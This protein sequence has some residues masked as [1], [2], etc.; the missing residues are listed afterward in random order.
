MPLAFTYNQLELPK[1]Y[2]KQNVTNITEALACERANFLRKIPDSPCPTE[3]NLSI[4]HSL[5]YPPNAD[6]DAAAPPVPVGNIFKFHQMGVQP[7]TVLLV[8]DSSLRVTAVSSNCTDW[9]GCGPQQLLGRAAADLFDEGQSKML[10]V[11]HALRTSEDSAKEHRL[12][13]TLVTP[14]ML[15]STAGVQL[16]GL[17]NKSGKHFTLELER[18]TDKQEE[19]EVYNTLKDLAAQL[20]AQAKGDVKAICN[21]VVGV[22]R[23]VLQYDR[24]I[25]YKF[26]ED[27]HGE[28]LA[29]SLSNPDFMSL[30]GLHFPG[31]DVPWMVRELL[32]ARR[33][34]W[35]YDVDSK[36]VHIVHNGSFDGSPIKHAHFV[37]VHP[38]HL[39]YLKNMGL[40]SSGTL[41]IV[42]PHAPRK[43]WG[44]IA[45]HG[46]LTAKP[47]SFAKLVTASLI[48]ELFCSYLA[49]ALHTEAHLRDLRV[50]RI[51]AMLLEQLQLTTGRE[52]SHWGIDM[53][54]M[55]GADG[56]ALMLSGNLL[57]M[58]VHPSHEQI[59]DMVKWLTE[60]RVPRG[61]NYDKYEA[62]P[63]VE[64]SLRKVGFTDL[65]KVDVCGVLL[66]LLDDGDFVVWF[67][68]ESACIVQWPA[69]A[70]QAAREEF[71]KILNPHH[72]F[73]LLS[74][75]Q[76]HCSKPW[77]ASDVLIAQN[78]REV[79]QDSVTNRKA[80]S[81]L[82]WEAKVKHNLGR[83]KMINQLEKMVVNLRKVVTS[84]H[85]SIVC[86]NTS[87]I[88]TEWNENMEAATGYTQD[89]ALGSNLVTTFVAPA[90]QQIVT[91]SIL[92]A[93]CGQFCENGIE[94][95]LKGKNSMSI[96][97]VA[98]FS[99]RIS[100]DGMASAIYV[101]CNNITARKEVE[102]EM[103]LTRAQLQDSINLL[104]AG[105]AIFDENMVLVICNPKFRQLFHVPQSSHALANYR[106]ILDNA[107]NEGAHESSGLPRDQ[108]IERVMEAGKDP[109]ASQKI[110][111]NNQWIAVSY[112]QANNGGAVCMYSDLTRAM[113]EERLRLAKEAAEASSNAKSDFLA[114]MSHEI[115]TP[116]NS[117]LG[118]GVLLQ[119]TSLTTEQEEYVDCILS[120]GKLLL[121]LISDILDLSKI[122][123]GM[124]RVEQTEFNLGTELENMVELLIPKAKEKS[125]Y[126]H[127]NIHPDVP[128]LLCGD[129]VKLRQVLLNLMGNAVK[130]TSS[131]SVS[132]SVSLVNHPS[133]P[134]PRAEDPKSG[135]A[136]KGGQTAQRQGALPT[137]PRKG[138]PQP[139]QGAKHGER[140][141]PNPPPPAPQGQDLSSP[142]SPVAG[143]GPQ[144]NST[145]GN[146]AKG[147]SIQ[148]N[149]AQGNSMQ[150]GEGSGSVSCANAA[151]SVTLH[152]EVQDTGIG[153]SEEDASKLFQRFT[154]A[155][156]STTRKYGGTGL[157]LVICRK[158][159]ELMSPNN[160]VDVRSK[161]GEGSCFWF[162]IYIQTQNV[163]YPPRDL[164]PPMPR[165][166]IL[167]HASGQLTGLAYNLERLGFA[168]E[169]IDEL[170]WDTFDKTPGVNLVVV[171][172][173]VY[174]SMD[175]AARIKKRKVPESRLNPATSRFKRPS[176]AG[177]SGS[178]GDPGT[179]LPITVTGSR[180]P[181]ESLDNSM[182]LRM[183]DPVDGEDPSCILTDDIPPSTMTL[184]VVRNV[185]DHG[186]RPLMQSP[187]L[188]LLRRNSAM[189]VIEPAE[190]PGLRLPVFFVMLPARLSALWALIKDNLTTEVIG[191][192]INPGLI[193][194]VISPAASIQA[195]PASSSEAE[196]NAR[197]SRR[198]SAEYDSQQ[199]QGAKRRRVL[200]AEDNPVNQRLFVKFLSTMGCDVEVVENGQQA[201]EKVRN[202]HTQFDICFM[203]CQMPTLDGLEATK[204]IR[205]EEAEAE[206]AGR[207]PR[208]LPIVAV[209]AN[210]F[211]ED[212]E[213]C[214]ACGMDDYI[215]KPVMKASILETLNR[216]T[217]LTRPE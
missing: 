61:E 202:F 162:D 186:A 69:A 32:L 47:V 21:V 213:R 150:G 27:E 198:S 116:M 53:M 108:W 153:I 168:T 194:R 35:I 165:A 142:M 29:E 124:M 60:R 206:R 113:E 64:V 148:G 143:D 173:E 137:S 92:Q 6:G 80:R 140:A 103:Q 192:L 207:K 37:E 215:T 14:L 149:G 93:A 200:L 83:V 33:M 88:I 210:A 164:S 190:C 10:D 132:V 144:G 65:D 127:C 70:D 183:D 34:R 59:L 41:G 75:I 98:M 167:N 159:L 195:Q 146:S 97:M 180:A 101:V 131:G 20:Q 156:A 175:V 9:M 48:C 136:Q 45:C 4:F 76:K 126:L 169:F 11:I 89:E 58:G 50:V 209:T 138:P 125:L 139:L 3:E 201:V 171:T 128:L 90:F 43:L 107:C 151:N 87:F 157:G 7:Q 62:P 19:F 68:K 204:I 205:R 54:D 78:F 23:K 184:L 28:V 82:R 118:Y 110:L 174:A 71:Q 12:Q 160:K 120:S 217:G 84:S 178:S 133:S 158:L 141:Q 203:D 104:D 96:D 39:Q 161:P 191:K 193:K 81:L 99:Q 109:N 189:E 13:L 31:T 56:V 185:I 67:R 115:R 15:R 154:Q 119:D 197:G 214:M 100:S 211:V 51:Q 72:S 77:S 44:I 135:P 208:H 22:V 147:K 46:L 112:A 8:L 121:T 5:C 111:V 16:K 105:V 145:Q 17:L 114:T 79:L 106:S 57:M 38:C 176:L 42:L 95:V 177:S 91:Q 74:S 130:F 152:F 181:R 117:V 36:P 212:R 49:Q 199:S 40:K 102:R 182:I 187:S 24:V 123:S 129:M 1:G 52:F 122:E 172:S 170:K 85:A 30:K 25:A 179:L 86:V 166:L 188:K 216:W 2:L 94:I 55:V 134:P 26:S 63:V 196:G 155:D 163:A 18:C 73:A 66:L